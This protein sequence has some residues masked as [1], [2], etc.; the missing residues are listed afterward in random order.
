MP[1]KTVLR[2]REEKRMKYY[3]KR[4]WKLVTMTVLCAI[5]AYGSATVAALASVEMLQGLLD[6]DFKSFAWA[7]AAHLAAWAVSFA[8]VYLENVFYYRAVRRMNDDVRRDMTA[9]MLCQSHQEVHA[10]ESG[11]YLS[12]FTNDIN[13]IEKQ[14]W[15]PFFELFGYASQVICSAIALAYLHWALLVAALV[16]GIVMLWMPDLFKTRLEKLS[17]NCAK[18][19]GAA[20]SRMKDLLAG[21]DVLRFFGKDERLLNGTY[22]ASEQMEDA[23]YRLSVAQSASNNS[24]GYLSVIFQCSIRFL[25]GILVLMGQLNLSAVISVSSLCADVYNGLK[26]IIKQQVLLASG[27]AYFDRLTVHADDLPVS[28]QSIAPLQDAI[29]V[30]NVSFHYDEKPVL[31][32][33][34]MRFEKGKKYALTG[35]SGCGKSTLLKLLLGW[36]PDY[37]GKIC[38]DGK[39]ARTYTP[40]QLQQQMSYIEQNVFLFNTTIRE[41]ITLGE[42]FSEEA[43]Q[44]AIEGSALT[45]DLAHMPNGLD[46]IVGEE[47]SNLSGGQKQR[48]AIARALIH[49]RGI[50]LVDEGTSA[51]D[52]KNADIVEKSLLANPDLTLILVSHHLTEER[53]KQFDQVYDMTA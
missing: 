15:E 45:N 44:K 33:A 4:S 22:Q 12:K 50:L 30:E 24:L 47:G 39:D 20:V 28:T 40:E 8:A 9:A 21:F 38:V 19:Q 29:T 23:R 48:V 52:Q 7:V 18:E 49:D 32:N 42:D 31:Q 1:N 13:Q 16:T 25:M 35:A 34:S 37:T 41:N 36:L 6:Q 14:G 46:T 3:L 26:Q 5:V 43:I 27:K 53:K 11:T 10:Q 2:K 51:L 17:A